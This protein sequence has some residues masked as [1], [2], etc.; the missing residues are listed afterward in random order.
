MEKVYHHPKG[1]W[2]QRLP[3]SSFPANLV[4]GYN[5]LEHF[6]EIGV[7][8]MSCELRAKFGTWGRD[9]LKYRVSPYRFCSGGTL[10]KSSS[11]YE[12]LEFCSDGKP[13]TLSILLGPYLILSVTAHVFAQVTLNIKILRNQLKRHLFGHT[14]WSFWAVFRCHTPESLDANAVPVFSWTDL[15]LWLSKPP[16]CHAYPQETPY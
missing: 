15:G 3:G 13:T 10:D 6:R 8:Y 9:I 7:F 16:K 4:G 5:P 1:T 11:V 2:W 14:V 12:F